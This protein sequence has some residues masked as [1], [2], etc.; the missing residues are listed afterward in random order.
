V[1]KD[2]LALAAILS[3]AVLAA[4]SSSSDGKEPLPQRRILFAEP[5]SP[6]GA[7]AS[8]LEARRPAKAKTPAPTAPRT[9]D[10]AVV[11]ISPAPTL[12]LTTTSTAASLNPLAMEPMPAVGNGPMAPAAAGDDGM[13]AGMRDGNSGGHATGGNRGP[14][15][16]IRGG[17]GGPE[18]KCDLRPRMWRGGIA[19]NRTVPGF[20]GGY[21]RGGP[22]GGIH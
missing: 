12:R 18:D 3:G 1:R 20:S 19:I 9:R 22:R 15:I 17:L 21:G 10:S 8:E 6:G 5:A 16:I 14:V 7:V 2:T 13:Y 11:A 4:C